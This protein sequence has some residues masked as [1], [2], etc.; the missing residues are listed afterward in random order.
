MAVERGAME[1]PAVWPLRLPALTH[2]IWLSVSL[3]VAVGYDCSTP[4]TP[5]TYPHEFQYFWAEV[6][7]ESESQGLV[8]PNVS[9]SCSSSVP[10]TNHR[11]Y[12]GGTAHG[13]GWVDTVTIDGHKRFAFFSIGGQGVGLHGSEVLLRDAW[14]FTDGQWYIFGGVD[15]TVWPDA[16]AGLAAWFNDS[17]DDPAVYIFG[18]WSN[19]VEHGAACNKADLWRLDSTLASF[20]SSTQNGTAIS[21]TLLSPDSVNGCNFAGSSSASGN[22]TPVWPSARTQPSTWK[23]VEDGHTLL[24]LAFGRVAGPEVFVVTTSAMND[25]WYY[26]LSSHTWTEVQSNAPKAAGRPP[27]RSS[28][29]LWALDTSSPTSRVWVFGGLN[30]SE[31]NCMLGD[32]WRGD[33]TRDSATGLFTI[34]WQDFTPSENVASPSRRGIAQ[35]WLQY[36]KVQTEINGVWTV[37]F[38]STLY[39]AVHA[40]ARRVGQIRTALLFELIIAS[41]CCCFCSITIKLDGCWVVS[42]SRR[43]LAAPRATRS[44]LSVTCGTGMYPHPNGSKC[45][46]TSRTPFLV[47]TVT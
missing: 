37:T 28:A 45:V 1:F 33:I 9:D 29:S 22:S 7:T 6:G 18:G 36:E 21:A 39:V 8:T 35:S 26:N 38:A 34:Q 25:V 44:K 42:S 41:V 47:A 43:H 32:M 40:C 11:M 46:Q 23:S 2:L 27:I 14:V 12:P 19:Q 3:Q 24:W 4:I 5:Q 30:S 16:R 10:C 15:E 20:N 17:P 31:F 13:Y